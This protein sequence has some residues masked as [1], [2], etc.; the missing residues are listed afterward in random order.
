MD[1]ANAL[2]SRKPVSVRKKDQARFNSLP[3]LRYVFNTYTLLLH[4][5]AFL[6]SYLRFE[7]LDVSLK[8]FVVV[9]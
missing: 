2:V 6:A 8:I 5:R 7:L 3:G 9:Y 4:L 1:M